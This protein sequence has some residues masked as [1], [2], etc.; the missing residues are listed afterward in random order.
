MFSLCAVQCISVKIQF[1]LCLKRFPSTM[2]Q[3]HTNKYFFIVILAVK[4]LSVN[5]NDML[6]HILLCGPIFKFLTFWI[7]LEVWLQQ[8]SPRLLSWKTD[9][10]F[11][12]FSLFCFW[13]GPVNHLLYTSGRGFT[14][15]PHS[16]RRAWWENMMWFYFSGSERKTLRWRHKGQK[17]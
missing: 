16:G 1:Y 12:F 8:W 9:L 17:K 10:S 6:L 5:R 3:T 15:S 11:S 14:A 4:I 13:R 2:Q 7:R